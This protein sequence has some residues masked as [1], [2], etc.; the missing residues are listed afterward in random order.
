MSGLQTL[1]F[2]KSSQNS[3]SKSITQTEHP[4]RR[5]WGHASSQPGHGASQD[6]T[7]EFGDPGDRTNFM[8]QRYEGE[9]SRGQPYNIIGAFMSIDKKAGGIQD[10]AGTEGSERHI[11]TVSVGHVGS[12]ARE[13]KQ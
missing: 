11:S 13:Q 10:R 9:S 6:H 3:P 8:L 5:E 7:H 2:K 1:S 4:V 12:Q